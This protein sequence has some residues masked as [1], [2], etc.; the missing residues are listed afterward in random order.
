MLFGNLHSELFLP[1]TRSS[2]GCEWRDL[3]GQRHQ[4]GSSLGIKRL[5]LI[6]HG[7]EDQMIL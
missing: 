4:T 1:R 3:A 6:R 7:G 2:V 5:A